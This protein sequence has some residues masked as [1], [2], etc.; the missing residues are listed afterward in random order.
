MPL[1]LT[2]PVPEVKP[3]PAR[4]VVLSLLLGAHPRPMTG[5]ELVGAG[6]H[7]G[8]APATVRVALSRA[9]AAGDVTREGAEHRLGRRL[10]ERRERQEHRPRA[11]AWDGDWEMVVV[12]VAGRPGAE[13][14]A[15]R[16][17]LAAARLAEL[18]EGVWTR[19]AN[20]ERPTPAD[21]T[22]TLFRA[23]P[24][25]DP[26]GLAARLWDLRG[27]AEEAERTTA[28]LAEAATPATRLALAARLVRHLAADPLLPAPLEP[29]GWPAARARAA[30]D[31]Y[32]RDLVAEVLGGTVTPGRP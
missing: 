1:W 5:A 24:D 13:R 17:R 4:S 26:A 20:L 14:S 9:V 30:Y 28:A 6:E 27:W 21:P 8:V 16:S 22:T 18:R 19:P 2:R 15:L 7:L 32:Q 12:T 29:P 10:V 31:G 3:L 11:A 25:D 23:R